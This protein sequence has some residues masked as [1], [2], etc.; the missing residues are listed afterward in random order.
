[1]GDPSE[2]QELPERILHR[3]LSE[4]AQRPRTDGPYA[5]NLDVDVLIVGAGFAGTYL[6]YLMRQTGFKTVLYEAGNSFGGTW[7]WNCYPGT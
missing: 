2:A 1:M 4:Y 5:D 7:K 6:L 3:D